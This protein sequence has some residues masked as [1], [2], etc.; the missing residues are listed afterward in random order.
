MMKRLIAFIKNLF[1]WLFTKPSRIILIDEYKKRCGEYYEISDIRQ[2]ELEQIVG[3]KYEIQWY[4]YSA[5]YT[6]N[7]HIKIWI[8]KIAKQLYNI[9]VTYDG[10]EIYPQA[11]Q[12]I[13]TLD[14]NIDQ[15]CSDHFYSNYS[16]K[17]LTLETIHWLSQAKNNKEKAL[18]AIKQLIIMHDPNLDNKIPNFYA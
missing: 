9:Y 17:W 5:F 11:N 8:K 14:F 1:L 12:I 13:S 6:E 10:M 18:K 4:R 15:L 16:F 3:E 2:C 7:P